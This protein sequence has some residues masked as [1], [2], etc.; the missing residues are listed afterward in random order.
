MFPNLQ[1][2]WNCK[3]RRVFRRYLVQADKSY[4]ITPWTDTSGTGRGTE[5]VTDFYGWAGL[6]V[7]KLWLVLG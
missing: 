6:I 3:L 2:S 7:R 1:S 4:P 5:K